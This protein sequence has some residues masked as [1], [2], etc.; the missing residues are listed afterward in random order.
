VGAGSQELFQQY[1]QAR[2]LGDD[3]FTRA[4][5]D[6]TVG[7]AS[8]LPLW[9][10]VFVELMESFAEA[11]TATAPGDAAPT[12]FAELGASNPFDDLL[13]PFIRRGERALEQKINGLDLSISTQAQARMLE[14]LGAR[15][16]SAVIHVVDNEMQTLH[17]AG[18]LLKQLGFAPRQHL[19]GS[20]AGWMA[21]LQ[22]YPVLARIIAVVFQNWR[23]YISEMLDRLA[24]DTSLL[25]LK[26]FAGKPLGTLDNFIGDAGDLHD[27]GRAVAL[28]L[29]D[30][31][32]R[33]AYKPKDLRISAAFLELTAL[34]N[35]SG[36]EL[37]LHVRKIITRGEYA[38]EEWVEYYPC[39]SEQEVERFYFRM[40]MQIRLLQF[41]GARDFWLDNL[42]ACGEHP[43]F[44]DLEMAF[45]QTLPAPPQL[46]P[47]ELLSF[48]KLIETVVPIGA[49][50]MVTPVGQGIK[51]EDLGA[52]T[53]VREFQTPFKFSYSSPMRNLIAPHL[54]KNDNAKWRKSDYAPVLNG[55]P[56]LAAE[57]VCEIL[58]GYR[59]MQ[60]CL[61]ENKAALG[62]EGGT[63]AAIRDFPLRHINRDTWSC[64]R[65]IN[66]STRTPLLVDGFNRELF[67]EGLVK[68]ALDGNRLDPKLVKI[69]ES[70]IESLRD[71][72]VPLFRA[73]PS[74]ATLFLSNGG[75]LSDYFSQTSLASIL[76]RL[77][78]IEDF[79]TDE[80]VDFISSSLATGPHQVSH[81]QNVNGRT[82]RTAATREYWLDEAVKL[83]DFILSESVRSSDGDL[84]WLGLIYHPDV[85]L[86]SIDVLRPDLLSGTCGLSVLFTSLYEMTG[87][88][89]FGE[90]A[91]AAL[92]S[93]IH[94]IKDRHPLV[95][96][97]ENTGAGSQRLIAC[98]AYYG[99]GGQIYSLRR[100]AEALK[101]AELEEMVT[102]YLK[103]LPLPKLMEHAH[104]DLISG[105]AGLLISILPFEGQAIR[106]E[107]QPIAHM[108]AGRLLELCQDGASAVSSPYPADAALLKGLPDMRDGLALSLA[109]LK[110]VSDALSMESLN[111]SIR[112]ALISLETRD[113]DALSNKP[114]LW[115]NL[116]IR[117]LS[118]QTYEDLLPHVRAQAAM[119]PAQLS[120][121]RL[122]DQLETMLT[123]FR[124]TQEQQLYERAASLAEQLIDRRDATGSWFPDSFAADRH[125]LSVM[126]GIGA[127]ASYFI[128]LYRPSE[129]RSIRE[130]E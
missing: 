22:R 126:H 68:V 117:R 11:T 78:S 27:H 109:R 119:A 54:K 48:N 16:A 49:I 34:L 26:L 96:L 92:A 79:E 43:V 89:R 88:A 65:I 105:L 38:W 25:E 28:L 113:T 47:A 91:R 84:S 35:S 75:T 21:R 121:Q 39:Q 2:G 124:M 42:I 112:Q 52:L 19:D 37:P 116:S 67:F 102:A 44:I 30:N 33:V 17:A 4:I 8:Q 129:M 7:D 10:E 82:A 23:N 108:L 66:D 56:A 18:G 50:A 9:A 98:G 95:R 6:G 76:D 14:L 99:V 81:T 20:L 122:L 60:A 93:T 107:A 110:R 32:N 40:G 5:S 94:S 70:E 45:Q 46:L 69:T 59:A 114:S 83:G 58:A 125:D 53:P 111:D 71:L 41:L 31:G 15:L 86:R 77:N 63:L 115:A 90:A 3:L 104:V 80:Q 24:D 61:R 101:S 127:V 51:A 128:H 64:I 106:V 13:S 130:L 72:D 74:D 118:G 55:R 1:L 100:C 36:L 123:A 57:H 120:S 29:F 97:L 85:D 73:L 62:S 87:F 12:P 103:M